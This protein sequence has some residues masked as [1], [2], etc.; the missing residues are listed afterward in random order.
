MRNSVFA[1]FPV[2]IK[3]CLKQNV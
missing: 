2:M 3:H 1:Y